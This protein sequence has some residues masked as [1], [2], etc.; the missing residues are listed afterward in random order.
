MIAGSYRSLPLRRTRSNFTLTASGS[1][2]NMVA[3][4]AA[5]TSKSTPG[6]SPFK[7]HAQGSSTASSARDLSRHESFRQLIYHRPYSE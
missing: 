2:G 4:A 3:R 1:T 7:D 6:Y 5:G